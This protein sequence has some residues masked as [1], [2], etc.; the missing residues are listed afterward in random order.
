MA[1]LHRNRDSDFFRKWLKIWWAPR[2]A[3]QPVLRTLGIWITERDTLI[4]VLLIWVVVSNIFYVHPYLV[5]WSSL[6]NIF[7]DGLKPP[8]SYGILFDPR[9]SFIQTLK[10]FISHG[11]SEVRLHQALVLLDD[12]HM[13]VDTT[14]FN[15]AIAALASLWLKK[16]HAKYHG[17]WRGKTRPPMPPYP[18]K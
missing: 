1:V 11:R 18:R 5:K 14:S 2:H 17:N 13:D 16:R 10:P 9:S 15:T 3:Q 7:S 12:R 8:S 6:T 4:Y